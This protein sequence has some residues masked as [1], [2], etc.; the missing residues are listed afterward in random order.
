LKFT[1]HRVLLDGG[2]QMLVEGLLT[3]KIID[4]KRTVENIGVDKVVENI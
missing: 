4:A 1:K 3:Y 2:I